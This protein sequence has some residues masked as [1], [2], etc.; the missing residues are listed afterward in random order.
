MGL[1]VN[2]PRGQQS[3]A[4][5]QRAAQLFMGKFAGYSYLQ[6]PKDQ[7]ADVDAILTLGNEMRQVVETKCRYDCDLDKFLGAY[8]GQWLVTYDKIVRS[9]AVAKALK[10]GL[11]GFVYL[12]PSKTLLVQRITDAAGNFLVPFE[13]K[14]TQTKATTNG[15][16]ATRA[17]A[18]VDMTN[19]LVLA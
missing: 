9:M 11:M 6:T 10:V 5:E 8:G 3:V 14:M 19:A 12:V 1:D 16:L 7:P 15:G 2:T 13:V 17:N 4:D 18:F